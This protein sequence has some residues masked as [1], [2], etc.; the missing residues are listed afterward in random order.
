ME[1]WGTPIFISNEEERCWLVSTKWDLLL[2]IE[3]SQ[4]K[5]FP[6]KLYNLKKNKK[7]HD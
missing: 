3:R 2:K 6:Q 7:N 4:S 1:P 5:L